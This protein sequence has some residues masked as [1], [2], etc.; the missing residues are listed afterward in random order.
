MVDNTKDGAEV[1]PAQIAHE[2]VEL[3]QRWL[4]ESAHED[5]GARTEDPAARRLA[6]VLG[7]PDGLDFAVG[8]VDGVARPQDLF[9]AGYNLQRVARRIPRFLPW[10]QRVA[11]W[12][13]GL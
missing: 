5:D 10:Y 6:G 4:A 9:V 12:L 7:D 13:A 2:A 11:I 1:R 8:F 3:V